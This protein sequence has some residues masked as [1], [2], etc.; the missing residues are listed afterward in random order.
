MTTQ[1]AAIAELKRGD[2]AGLAGLVEIHQL[3]ALRTVYG[4]L[5]DRAA[6]EEVV[7]EAFLKVADGIS[8]FGRASPDAPS[9]RITPAPQPGRLVVPVVASAARCELRVTPYSL[10][11]TH[12]RN[13]RV[14]W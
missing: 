11:S 12:V 3:K 1:D 8:R 13:P 14:A 2:M 7:S 9:G 6:A 10:G 5:G 4:I